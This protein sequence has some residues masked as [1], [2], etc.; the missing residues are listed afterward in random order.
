MHRNLFALFIFLFCL[1]KVNARAELSQADAVSFCNAY[2]NQQ[3][4]A[5]CPQTRSPAWCDSGLFLFYPFYVQVIKNNVCLAQKQALFNSCYYGNFDSPYRPHFSK[6]SQLTIKTL[7][8]GKCHA[9]Y[10]KTG[11]CY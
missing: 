9:Q 6:W 1:I 4:P 2:V 3:L 10:S 7:R 11:W 8:C 5:A